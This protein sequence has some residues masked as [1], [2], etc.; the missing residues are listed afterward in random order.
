M[1]NAWDLT[2]LFAMKNMLTVTHKISINTV[3]TH[4]S[5]VL[6]FVALCDGYILVS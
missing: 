2:G 5:W 4:D 3:V 1:Q 6:C